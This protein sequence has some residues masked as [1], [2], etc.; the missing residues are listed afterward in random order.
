MI[1]LGFENFRRFRV[2]S[3]LQFGGITILVG[4][5]NSGKSTITKALGLLNT[6]FKQDDFGKFYF[7]R[8][9]IKE[10]NTGDYMSSRNVV[11]E[12]D[13]IIFELE[14]KDI[15]I[16]IKIHNGFN[17]NHSNVTEL[18]LGDNYH[19]IQ[20]EIDFSLKKVLITKKEN[21][22]E[23]DFDTS[24]LITRYE[25]EIEQLNKRKE[26]ENLRKVSKEYIELNSQISKLFDKIQDLIF[27]NSRNKTTSGFFIEGSFENVG[28]IVKHNLLYSNGAYTRKVLESIIDEVYVQNELE[29][30]KEFINSQKGLIVSENFENLKS[31]NDNNL[32]SY[33]FFNVFESLISFNF[34]YLNGKQNTLQTV[35]L[36]DEEKNSFSEIIGSWIRNRILKGDQEYLFVQEWLKKFEIGVDFEIA[37]YQNEAYSLYIIDKYQQKVLISNQGRGSMG[38]IKLLMFIGLYIKN[39]KQEFINSFETNLIVIEEPEANLHP[40][41]QSKLADLFLEV[42]DKFRIHF[43]IETHSEYILRRSQVFV[44]ENEFEA[45][46]NENPFCIYYLPTDTKQL[47]YQMEFNKDGSFKR[48]FGVGFFD[49]A[50]SSTLELLKIKRQKKD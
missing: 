23:P 39:R 5:N 41:L 18:L 42:Y 19:N 46:S 36:I 6:Y 25:N 47:Y 49:E 4:Q 30:Q 31:F 29:Y 14:L 7:N 45:E 32:K 1:K 40:A 24:D 10:L 34:H 43:L 27:E 44:A 35:N 48:N 9:D 3:P 26:N 13:H 12:N 15:F 50:S 20:F 16:K 22:F 8:N 37:N 33:D 17:Q 11:A 21:V 38:L 2:L 28:D